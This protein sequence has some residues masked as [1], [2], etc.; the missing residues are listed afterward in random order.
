MLSIFVTGLVACRCCG[1]RAMHAEAQRPEPALLPEV[2]A[3]LI[4]G[5]E[6]RR[7]TGLVARREHTSKPRKPGKPV[8]NGWPPTST[9]T[10][11]SNSE[12]RR[13]HRH[14]EVASNDVA[15][16]LSFHRERFGES[17]QH[18]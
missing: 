7:R 15:C 11:D 8:T 17:T 14:C 10:P 4:E 3:E 1:A 6:A 13:A 5:H 16:R 12:R 18:P 2:V 9:S